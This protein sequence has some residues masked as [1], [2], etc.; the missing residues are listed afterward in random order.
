MAKLDW[1]TETD[2]VIKLHDKSRGGRAVYIRPGMV[3]SVAE[4]DGFTEVSISAPR[5][6]YAIHAAEPADDVARMVW[7]RF[8]DPPKTE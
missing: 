4:Q 7:P 6:N 5:G 8:F 3:E 2:K 1:M